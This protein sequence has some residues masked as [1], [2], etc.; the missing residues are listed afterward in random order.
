MPERSANRKS[1]RSKPGVSAI[2]LVEVEGPGGQ[3]L[4]SA[5][6]S[7][8]DNGAY[9]E[10]QRLQ[11]TLIEAETQPQVDRLGIQGIRRVQPEVEVVRLQHDRTLHLL[12]CGGRGDHAQ[13][14]RHLQVLPLLRRHYTRTQNLLVGLKRQQLALN[15][16][17]ADLENLERLLL[18]GRGC[19]VGNGAAGLGRGIEILRRFS[20]RLYSGLALI[21]CRAASLSLPPADPPIA[22]SRS[23]ASLAVS[24]FI[25]VPA[26]MRFR[27]KESSAD[28]IASWTFLSDRLFCNS[29]GKLA[30]CCP[31][32]SN[33][34]TTTWVVASPS[35]FVG[36]LDGAAAINLLQRDS[37]RFYITTAR[38]CNAAGYYGVERKR[39]Y[40]SIAPEPGQYAEK[41]GFAPLRSRLVSYP[42]TF[43]RQVLASRACKQA[44]S[45]FF[46]A[47]Y[48][49][50]RGS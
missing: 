12:H 34:S 20:S 14:D 24:G 7:V 19:E 10:L 29:V 2:S 9:A 18:E 21:C 15:R 43:A 47:S 32:R 1:R 39:T 16:E 27:M 37:C 40:P 35:G 46:T 38:A 13:A 23:W 41:A 49:Y 22:A 36:K 42:N 30:S 33:A 44:M 28:W 5:Y 50:G 25:P 4:I 45:G 3:P 8:V 31:N 11:R 17:L 6:F 48:T 26:A